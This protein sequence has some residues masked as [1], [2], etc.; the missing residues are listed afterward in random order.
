MKTS[1]SSVILAA[2]FL[3][4]GITAVVSA[5]PPKKPRL[6][7]YTRLW[8]NSPFTIKPEVKPKAAESPLERDWML[9]SISPSG[10]GYTVTLIN[11]KDRKNRIRFIPGV[12][13]DGYELLDVKQDMQNPENS[14]VEISKGS[15]K[16]WITYVPDLVKIR[17]ATTAKK[18]T[19]S[20]KKSARPPV[21][22]SRNTGNAVNRPRTRSTGR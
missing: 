6:T 7:K 14:R 21:P 4:F 12:P 9:G 15:Q 18:P 22:G 13:S 1:S 5:D 2:L 20:N 10:E 11:K 16:A 3:S 8:T 19:A 17:T